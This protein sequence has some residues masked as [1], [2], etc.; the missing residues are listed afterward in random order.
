[1]TS[2]LDANFIYG[3][4]QETAKKLRTFRGGQLRS[5]PVLRGRGLKDLLPSKT[6]DPDAGCPRPGRDVFC[7]EAG[8]LYLYLRKLKSR[9]NLNISFY[10]CVQCR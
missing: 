9:I 8:R 5:N 3:S 7:F 2:M 1:M 10:L 6:V 4:D